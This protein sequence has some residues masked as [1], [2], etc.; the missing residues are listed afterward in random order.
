MEAGVFVLGM[1]GS[2][3]SA[4][5]RLI[6]LLGLRTP[7]EED[8]VQST[9]KN[10][11][12]YWESKSLVALNAGIL[13]A[14]GCDMRCPVALEPGWEN[15]A[16]LDAFRQEAREIVRRVY[17]Q[18]PWVW[19]DP[20]HCLAF[21][22]WRSTLA[23]RPTV[24]LVNRNPLEIA[25]SALRGWHTGK[26]FGLALWER[27]LRQALG[28]ITGLPVLVT[29][30]GELLS[31]PLAWCERTHAFLTDAGV[32]AHASRESDVL[33]FVD[34][35]LRHSEFTRADVL[36]DRDV[37]DAQRAL[38]LA[39]EELEGGHDVFSAPILPRETP[40]TEALL[41]ERRRALQ[42]KHDLERLLE[43]ERQSRGWSRLRNSRYVAPARPLYAG[44]RRLV[45]AL[46]GR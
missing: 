26:I 22:F 16:R 9:D 8:L 10:P 35:R 34:A 29:N 25:A 36:G 46:Q 33:A 42:I 45:K 12:G 21:A 7:P 37:S 23:V 44:G 28:Q 43:I 20:R 41:A 11:K 40:T 3:T 2:G 15:D 30:F 32:P 27:Y 13:F 1:H 14:V 24:V 19:K 5:T 4:V 18:A 6:N 31:A 38:F 39:L 17:P